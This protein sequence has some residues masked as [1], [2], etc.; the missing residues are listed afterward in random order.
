MHFTAQKIRMESTVENLQLHSA[1]DTVF[2][3]RG[4]IVYDRYVP[5]GQ[6]QLAVLKVEGKSVL[7]NGESYD[8]TATQFNHK[9]APVEMRNLKWAYSLDGG[10]TQTPFKSGTTGIKNDNAYKNITIN[11]P[12][13]IFDAVIY[14]YVHKIEEAATLKVKILQREY[15]VI[16]GTEQHSPNYGNKLMF[17][18]QAVRSVRTLYPHKRYCTLLLFTDGYNKA[19]RDVIKR[20]VF[21]HNPLVHFK[22][23]NSK[24]ALVDYLNKGDKHCDRS[25]IIVKE[26]TIFSHGLPS[27][28]DFGLDGSN[29]AVQRFGIGDV[30]S[31]SIPAFSIKPTVYSYACRTGNSD[32]RLVTLNPQYTYGTDWA[33]LVKPQSSLAQVLANHLNA[34][35]YAYLRRSFY[36]NTWL[37]GGDKQYKEQYE[38]VED[39]SINGWMT[40]KKW[41][42]DWDEAL[43]NSNGAVSGPTAGT[44][45]KGLPQNMYIFRKDK[46][47]I[48]QK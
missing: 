46:D 41:I 18:A 10:K 32:S 47:P 7:E 16:A 21:K 34:E 36:M 12:E 23:L 42:V 31:L 37:D 25:K 30:E 24:A 14:A 15:V 3:A 35:V 17:P 4:K 11:V 45:P 20:D 33:T 8:F 39:E 26:L 27:I 29:E 48:P 43:W 1:H 2:K 19:E 13:D 22:E 5:R 44:T 28:L 40:P 38:E 6:Q 9:P